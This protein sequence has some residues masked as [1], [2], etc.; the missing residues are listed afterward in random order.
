MISYSKGLWVR[1]PKSFIPEDFVMCLQITHGVRPQLTAEEFRSIAKIAFHFG[2]SNTVRYCEEQLIKINEQPNLI[3]KNFKMAVNFNMERYM[4]HL[5]IHIVSAKQLINILSKL[6]LEGMSSESMKDQDNMFDFII[7]RGS[8][9]YGHKQ[10]VKFH[11]KKISDSNKD[12]IR[13]PNSIT[14]DDFVI[15]LQITH[16]A[17]PHMTVGELEI[18]LKTAFHFG[19]SSTVRYC[20]QQLIEMDA[21][22]KVKLTRKIKLAV[23]F[24]MERYLKISDLHKGWVRVP[25][26]FNPG[27]FVMCLQITHGVRPQLSAGELERIIGFASHFGFT[28]AIRYCE[29]RLIEMKKQP[30][31]KM[32]NFKMAVKYNMK[33]YMIHLLIHIKSAK[34]LVNILSKLNLEEMSSESM[35]AFAAKIF[36]L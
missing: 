11:S 22:I 35:K 5:L 23:K 33:R 18:V 9:L 32:R 34:Q 12:W 27:D 26:S 31:L 14:D 7:R 1:V 16:G 30:E 8:Y 24:N 29:G 21:Q 17:R 10:I 3:I 2:F 36:S 13:V 19:F 6:D 25:K 15:C 4:I 20:E 28:N